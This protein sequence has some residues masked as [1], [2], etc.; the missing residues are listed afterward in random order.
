[1]NA[2]SGSR[3]AD[4]QARAATY[5]RF[6][7]N[8]DRDARRYHAGAKAAAWQKQTNADACKFWLTAAGHCFAAPVPS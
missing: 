2:L 4:Y 6:A 1:M 5:R 3:R 8:A 7:F